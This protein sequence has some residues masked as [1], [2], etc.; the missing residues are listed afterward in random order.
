[1]E[2]DNR[3]RST[4]AHGSELA[5]EAGVLFQLKNGTLFDTPAALAKHRGGGLK[6]LRFIR[7]PLNLAICIVNYVDLHP[8]QADCII[9]CAYLHPS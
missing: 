6:R 9:N 3:W 1:M 8:S 7:R 5:D 2:K 4:A